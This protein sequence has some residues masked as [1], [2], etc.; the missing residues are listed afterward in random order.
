MPR[1]DDAARLGVNTADIGD[2]VRVATNGATDSESTH[3][4]SDRQQLVV[5]VRLPEGRLLDLDTIRN[6]R[7]SNIRQD[8]TVPDRCSGR[9]R[10][11]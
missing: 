3:F 10:L 9:C 8:S 7:V 1:Q 2:N 5:R 4:K 6:L 11:W